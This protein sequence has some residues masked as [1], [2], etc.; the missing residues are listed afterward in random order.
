MS[1]T[2]LGYQQT[3]RNEFSTIIGKILE[4]GIM[5]ENTKINIREHEGETWCDIYLG[6]SLTCYDLK[7]L[8][9]ILNG[10]WWCVGDLFNKEGYRLTICFN[11]LAL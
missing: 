10:W 11:D 3:H 8:A 1:E 4:R 7:E 6:Y 2:L 5:L 9:V